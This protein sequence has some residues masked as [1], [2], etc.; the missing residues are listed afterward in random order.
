MKLAAAAGA[1]VAL[2]L[3][4]AQGAYA[5]YVTKSLSCL[6]VGNSGQAYVQ[7]CQVSAVFGTVKEDCVCLPG[8][9]LYDP[10]SPLKIES[11]A[12]T[13]SGP[14]NATDG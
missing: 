8:Y 13:G 11:G 6:P 4:M 1:A 2:S 10:E 7:D 9:V 12:S 3:V 5:H 14:R